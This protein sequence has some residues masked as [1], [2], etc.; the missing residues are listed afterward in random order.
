MNLHFDMIKTTGYKSKSQIAR[1]A[2]ENWVSKNSYCP[3]CGENNLNSYE[4]NKPVADFH[5]IT[6]NEDYELK[7]KTGLL[8]KKIVD[9]AYSTMIQRI[10]SDTNPNFFFLT[11]SPTQWVVNDFLIIPK[12]F[13]TPEVIEKRKPL[14]IN[15]R[16]AGWI[17]CNIDL[18]HIPS[19]G[20]IFLIKETKTVEKKGS[21]I[22]MEGHAFS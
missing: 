12:H 2:T 18:N 17:G 16:R 3:N 5:C 11:Y 1:V 6:C 15:A 20:R 9:G 14:S 22:K 4:G 21:I 7:S 19:L 8:S 13:F 10:T